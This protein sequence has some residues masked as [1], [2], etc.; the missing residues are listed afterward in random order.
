MSADEQEIFHTATPADKLQTHQSASHTQKH[1]S[2][3]SYLYTY[4][5]DYTRTGT[6]AHTNIQ[7]FTLTHKKRTYLQE[8][9]S[10][11]IQTHTR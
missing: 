3:H 5:I 8:H 1:I 9:L 11:Q 4:L 10:T 2:I 7:T 6:H